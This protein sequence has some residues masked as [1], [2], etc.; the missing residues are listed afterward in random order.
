[1]KKSIIFFLIF[2]L[3]VF[4]SA[5]GL[6]LSVMASPQISWFNP[7]SKVMQ[8]DG[9]LTGIKFGLQMDNFFSKHYAFSSGIYIHSTGGKLRFN[10][11]TAIHFEEA[12]DTIPAG[13]KLTYKLNYITVPLG[14]K[15][16]TREI[17]YSTFF[18]NLGFDTQVR[19]KAKADLPSLDY[20]NE[21]VSDEISLFGLSYYLGGGVQYSLGGN[22][23][24]VGGIT[25]QGGI[26]DVLSNKNLKAVVNSVIIQIGILF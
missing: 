1:M 18:V 9:I 20:K 4:V 16:T 26:N 14:L 10:E 24:L 3:P 22:T 12:T 21:L 25:Y 2:S 13:N 19:F 6:K 7:E 11:R 8:N 5:Q 17:G 23:A 15:L